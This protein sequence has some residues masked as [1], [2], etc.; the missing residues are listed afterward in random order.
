METSELKYQCSK[1]DINSDYQCDLN[2][3]FSQFPH[4]YNFV[5]KSV[6]YIY[7]IFILIK[8]VCFIFLEY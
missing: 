8:Y 2:F 4:L 7:Y 5:P 3:Y 1:S 6:I